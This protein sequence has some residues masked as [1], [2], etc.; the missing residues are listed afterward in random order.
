[1]SATQQ[2]QSITTHG[3]NPA[4]VHHTSADLKKIEK[5]LSKEE[6]IDEKALKQAEKDVKSAEKT[7]TK[8]EKVR[9]RTS[10]QESHIT[11]AHIPT[12]QTTAKAVKSHE[13]AIKYEHKV[14]QKIQQEQKNLDRAVK[15][16]QKLAN[17]INVDKR[18]EQEATQLLQKAK[19]DAERV[20][21]QEEINKSRRDQ[22]LT[23]FVTSPT[24]T[25]GRSAA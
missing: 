16:E 20:K 4:P 1:M 5:Q 18:K 22:A 21:Q 8:A 2:P 11:N 9:L 10:A 13:K 24:S 12:H 14:E 25:I 7:L 23:E 3:T 19:I 15:N 6:K 17:E